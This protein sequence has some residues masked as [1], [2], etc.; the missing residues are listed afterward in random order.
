MARRGADPLTRITAE[1]ARTSEHIV[2]LEGYAVALDAQLSA[3]KQLR[4]ELL[5]VADALNRVRLKLRKAP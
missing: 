3:L 1:A 5:A 4:A 2:E